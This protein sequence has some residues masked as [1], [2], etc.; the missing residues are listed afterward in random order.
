MKKTAGLLA[1]VI[2]S[3]ALILSACSARTPI[4]ADD[5]QKKAEAAG[6]QVTQ[7]TS[8]GSD[9]KS[10]LA[11]KSGSDTQ[12]AFTVFTDSSLAQQKYA[13]LKKSLTVTGGE[14][15]VDADAYNKYT[16]ENGEIYYTIIRMDNTLLDCKGTIAKK[17][18]VD[19]FVKTVKY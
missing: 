19:S 5:F 13:S 7:D 3:A 9:A 17:D 18:E 10:L 14:S 15:T 16:A 11:S 12:F 6:Y 4:S 8:Y 1:A 2:L